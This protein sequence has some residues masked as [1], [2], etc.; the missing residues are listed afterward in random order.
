MLETF[1][2]SRIA[3]QRR[4]T[5]QDGERAGVPKFARNGRPAAYLARR[6]R[7]GWLGARAELLLVSEVMLTVILSFGPFALAV[8]DLARPSAS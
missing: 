6:T 5:G 8:M 4:L 7:A 3:E 1:V 2:A